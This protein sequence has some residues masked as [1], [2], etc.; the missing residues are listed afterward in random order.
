MTR[1][2]TYPEMLNYAKNFLSPIGVTV[3]TI[4]ISDDDDSIKI[5]VI[6][7]SQEA[8]TMWFQKDTTMVCYGEDDPMDD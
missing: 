6:T 1:D 8:I 7:K 4:T 5:E 3:Q 2:C